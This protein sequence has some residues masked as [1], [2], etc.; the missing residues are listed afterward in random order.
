SSPSRSSCGDGGSARRSGTGGLV[1]RVTEVLQRESVGPSILSGHHQVADRRH[2]ND[3]SRAEGAGINYGS[4][5]SRA[6][7][8]HGEGS[9][10]VGMGACPGWTLWPLYSLNPLNPLRTY[11]SSTP[12]WPLWPRNSCSPL[13]SLGP[14]RSSGSVY[15]SGALHRT[16]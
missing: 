11:G 1:N 5:V 12:N 13:T 8:R 2:E 14:S 3:N 4:W 6:D 7:R 15:A 16:E 9:G 10:Q